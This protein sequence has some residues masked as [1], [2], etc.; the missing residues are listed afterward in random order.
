MKL[1]NI[2]LFVFDLGGT[3]MEYKGIHLSWN[4][5]YKSAFEYVN[6]QLSLGLSQQQIKTSIQILSS[7]NPSINPRE[8]EI[9]PE[10]IF[11]ETTKDWKTTI[12]MVMT[13]DTSRDINAAKNIGCPF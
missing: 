9:D 12:S 1:N 10:I 8:K 11:P 2:K 6:Q 3:L 13:G 7:F 4:G 5:Y